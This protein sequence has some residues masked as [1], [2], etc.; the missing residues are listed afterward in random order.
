MRRSRLGSYDGYTQPVANGY[1]R[2]SEYVKVRD[3]C[4]LA[5]DMLHPAMNGRALGGRRPT[6]VRGTGYR[7]AFRRSEHVAYDVSRIPIIEQYPVGS[8]I[9][10]YELAPA[11]R[12]LVDHGYVFV[13]IDLRGTGAS[14]GSYDQPA[15]IQ[16]GR[17]LVDVID[18][19]AQQDW[20][21]G[22]I[23]MW[24][25]SWEA[26]VQLVTL[27]AGTR[28]LTCVC[29][30]AVGGSS[31]VSTW[32]NGLFAVGF[33]WP[34]EKLRKVMELDELAMPVDG[35]D[36][37]RLRGEAIS[38]RPGY[39]PWPDARALSE[40]QKDGAYA[41]GWLHR[42]RAAGAP[43]D[44]ALGRP[45]MVVEDAAAINAC[46]AAL[47]WIDGWW[48]LNCINTAVSLYNALTVPKKMTIGPWTHSQF[49]MAH[50][51]HRWFDFWLKGVDNGIMN[52]PP[53]HYSVSSSDGATRWRGTQRLPVA[54]TQPRPLFPSV[55]PGSDPRR[56]G[57]LASAPG[58]PQQLHYVTDYQLSTGPQTR[59]TY[60]WKSTQMRYGN[61]SR[62][63]GRCL[64]FTSEPFAGDIELTGVP[65]LR[66]SV[67]AS[68]APAA[69]FI[70]LEEVAP[71]GS[72][73][74]LTEGILN[75]EYRVGTSLPPEGFGHV[76]HP[77][78]P[79]ER[80]A[81]VP[82]E[83]MDITL[84]MLALGVTVRARHRLRL[85]IAGADQENYFITPQVP[86][87][88]LT[89]WCGDEGARLMLPVVPATS[90]PPV[91][92]GIFEDDPMPFAFEADGNG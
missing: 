74:Y 82:G 25:R 88:E 71:D 60:L 76:T 17:D 46:G 39:F 59:S 32:Y 77:A 37:E 5:V 3:G 19:M 79:P 4:L 67:A 57:A 18:W 23:G 13:S 40:D 11:A 84:D 58:A 7:R 86:P 51:P 65:T 89:L 91:V 69:V 49:A 45:R 14:F 31:F 63:V 81:I 53:V 47:Y 92:E 64:T 61:L 48:D 56:F 68:A 52:E 87:V 44:P 66:L 22:K 83:R 21:D 8:I 55:A 36:G 78:F 30:M 10:P 35:Q 6:V 2:T 75:F 85:A 24:G 33:R 41:T 43:D 50:E 12:R 9:T 38:N 16:T 27:V 54:G 62:R 90:L 15:T 26:S 42:S 80:R 34:Y 29:P 70:T 20:S 73:R 72:S 28:N 1:V